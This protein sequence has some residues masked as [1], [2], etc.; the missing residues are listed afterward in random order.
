MYL[1]EAEYNHLQSLEANILK[2]KRYLYKVQHYSLS[3]DVFE[4][5][6]LGLILA[7]MEFE[8]KAGIGEFVLPSFV[9]KNVTDDRFFTGGNLIALADAEFR[10]GLSQR[11]R[12]T[13]PRLKRKTE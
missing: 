5:C 6:H 13:V 12:D 11:M 4:G 1:S 7:E 8:N 2:K 10:Q 3:I 9:L